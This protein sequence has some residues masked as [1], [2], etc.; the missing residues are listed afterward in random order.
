MSQ[1]ISPK[2]GSSPFGGRTVFGWLV[3]KYL[4]SI[5]QRK[6]HKRN[7]SKSHTEGTCKA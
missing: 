3:E 1:V 7:E 6:I 4:A 2:V 5:Q